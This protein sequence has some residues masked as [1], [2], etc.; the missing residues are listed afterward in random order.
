M[1]RL[2]DN[3]YV[4]QRRLHN[5]ALGQTLSEVDATWFDNLWLNIQQI[6]NEHRRALAYTYGLGVGD[7]VF[8]FE[9]E[10]MELRRPLSDVF[11]ALWRERRHL[12]NNG[13]LNHSLNRDAHD[14]VRS[15]K[16]DLMFARLPRPEG[17][18]A[19]RDSIIGWRELWASGTDGD[20]DAMVA[21]QRGRLGDRVMSKDHYLQL[22]AGFLARAKH[23]SR[24]A[25]SH[26]E[27]GFI[28]AAE[29]GEVIGQ[30][31]RI[32][33]T[34]HKDFSDVI[35]GRNTFILVA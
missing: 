26:T 35:G 34:Y 10:T 20:W 21:G 22:V 11:T 6:E 18:S 7:Y 3:V 16:A 9:P 33:V 23:I 17:L 27:D 30:F 14:F 25:L 24:W 15:I 32:E 4:P 1:A 28:S 5:P 29:L 2:L 12:V 8:S 19:L 31:R 13:Q